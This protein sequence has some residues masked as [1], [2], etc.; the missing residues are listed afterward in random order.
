M[1]FNS[2]FNNHVKY[3]QSNLPKEQYGCFEA[4]LKEDI[5]QYIIHTSNIL[6][7][8]IGYLFDMPKLV[9]YVKR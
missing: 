9:K 5:R 8:S 2:V 1:C 3:L 7:V 6:K 4:F